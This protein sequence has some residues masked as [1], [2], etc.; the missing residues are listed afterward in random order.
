MLFSHQ[1]AQ[2]L[3]DKAYG[4]EEYPKV[5]K[6]MLEEIT[7]DIKRL[8]EGSALYELLEVLAEK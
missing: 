8:P 1:I 6:I 3:F 4:T 7:D 5:D 2:K